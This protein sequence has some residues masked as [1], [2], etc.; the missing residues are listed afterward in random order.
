[1]RAGRAWNAAPIDAALL[2]YAYDGQRP[3]VAAVLEHGSNTEAARALGITPASVKDVL[4]RVR[5]RATDAGWSPGVSYTAPVSAVGKPPQTGKATVKPLTD[6]ARYLVELAQKKPLTLES[7]CDALGWPPAPVRKLAADAAAGGYAIEFVG[8]DLTW[9]IPEPSEDVQETAIAPVVGG[10]HEVAIISDLHFGSKWCGRAQLRDFLSRVR[11]R[12]I[13]QILGPGDNLDGNYKFSLYEQSHR[14]FDEQAEDF[15]EL[16]RDF[17]GLH[18]HTIDG[19]H[20][21]TLSESCGMLAGRALGERLRDNGV[22]NYTHYGQRSAFL[23]IYGAIVHL[24]HP[25]GSG[26]YALSYKLQK[27]VEGY[28]PGQKPDILLTGHFHQGCYIIER[29]VHGLLCSTFQLPGSPFGNSLTGSPSVGGTI[30]GWEL[31]EN[32]TLRNVVVE[33]VNY[34]AEEKPRLIAA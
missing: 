22:T 18:L 4:R 1:M 5:K 20:D 27:K 2:E 17:P 33:R 26:S 34:Y 24:W 13:T 32:R 23:N 12:G 6:A 15:Y 14:G 29:G 28:A 16:W 3:I 19:N 10:R 8:D 31:T 11:D 30:L 25:S 21:Q 9:R 7:A